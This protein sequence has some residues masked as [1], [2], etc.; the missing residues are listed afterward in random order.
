[1][2]VCE[3]FKFR[4]SWF[5]LLQDIKNTHTCVLLCSDAHV[6][7]VTV[8][9]NCVFLQSLIGYFIFTGPVRFLEERS[10]PEII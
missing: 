10:N 2:Q 8:Q 9:E 7:W 4:D 1:M 6:L 3:A 5:Y